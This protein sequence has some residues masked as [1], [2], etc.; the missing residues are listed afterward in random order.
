MV[1]FEYA[2]EV[3]EHMVYYEAR[4]LPMANS[5]LVT[6]VRDITERTNAEIALREG[7]AR[8]RLIIATAFDAII[9][10]DTPGSIIVWNPQAQGTF[11]LN[12][13]KE[14][15]L[16]FLRSETT[17][18]IEQAPEGV[19][20]VTTIVRAMKDFSHRETSEKVA[21]DL[22]WAIQSA[23]RSAAAN[24]SMSQR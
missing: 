7:E 8:L 5:Q 13:I 17:K 23:I 3:D 11:G 9:R 2:L 24:G 15:D 12:A 22:N 10:T 18:A 21:I 6:V 14:T 20:R 1:S 4:I 16:G 19:D